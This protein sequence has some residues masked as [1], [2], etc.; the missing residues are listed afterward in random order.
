MNPT[1]IVVVGCGGITYYQMPFILLLARRAQDGLI[2]HP[3]PAIRFID[4][5]TVEA[6]NYRRQWPNDSGQAKANL[7][8]DEV[9]YVGGS[10]DSF[11]GRVEDSETF[12]AAL[13]AGRR[14]VILV[15]PDNDQ[16]REFCAQQF[17]AGAFVDGC[18]ITAGCDVTG[19]N[20][21]GMAKRAGNLVWDFRSDLEWTPNAPEGPSCDQQ[22]ALAN[23]MAASLSAELFEYMIQWAPGDVRIALYWELLRSRS[24][25]VSF[26]NDEAE[27]AEAEAALA[28]A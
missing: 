20:V 1:D 7:C 21:Y 4:P 9:Q 22:T 26:G 17:E 11:V 14:P 28:T 18:L 8:R 25:A 13:E 2:G 16:C 12:L 19:A 27:R 3:S 6:A 5:D 15:N 23:M 10:S 24:Y